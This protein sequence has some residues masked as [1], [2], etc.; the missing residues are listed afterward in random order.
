[1]LRRNSPVYL[2]HFPQIS[3]FPYSRFGA[4]LHTTMIN[5]DEHARLH[6]ACLRVGRGLLLVALIGSALADV[7]T[8]YEA[9]QLAASL[10]RSGNAPAAV[11]TLAGYLESAPEDVAARV[12]MARYL[13]FSK[14]YPEALLQYK[15][16]LKN[17]PANIASLLGIAKI[18][19][20]EGDFPAALELYER[21][22][23]RSP[24]FYDARVGKAF[25]LLW[26][27]EKQQAAEIFRWAV[28]VHPNDREV[29]GALQEIGEVSPPV[30]AHSA[31]QKRYPPKTAALPAAAARRIETPEVVSS[32][33][34]PIAPAVAL[35]PDSSLP[36]A[37]MAVVLSLAFVM[38]GAL[39]FLWRNHG[40]QSSG[41]LHA[42]APPAS[43]RKW[44]PTVLLVDSNA[45]ALEFKRS[46]FASAGF[47]VVCA[48]D[49]KTALSS[50]RDQ[51]F[52]HV[53]I[54]AHLDGEIP[55]LEVQCWIHENHPALGQTMVVTAAT[56]SEADRIQKNTG[57]HCIAKPLRMADLLATAP[58]VPG[59][60]SQ[61]VTLPEHHLRGA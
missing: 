21:V 7:K 61:V 55:S 26:M 51:Q 30:Q 31:G 39:V 14:R 53:V 17:D 4:K 38:C 49:G 16:V 37:A 15:L 42:M 47:H 33:P 29:R 34:E 59:Q 56:S 46:V 36:A 43:E 50:L 22:L 25:T 18:R 5:M 45:G 28:R 10:Y 57:A 60:A 12:E 58:A 40:S 11:Q 27:G 1:V 23:E 35:R 20:W 6:R 3:A 54:D 2:R 48:P 52:E 41:M 8:H 9:M 44:Q 19:S 32:F 24:H 13:A